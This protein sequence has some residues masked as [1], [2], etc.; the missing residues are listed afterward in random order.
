M[1]GFLEEINRR[2]AV[3]GQIIFEKWSMVYYRGG[4]RQV[5]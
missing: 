3:L 2:H 1:T 4:T 5:L